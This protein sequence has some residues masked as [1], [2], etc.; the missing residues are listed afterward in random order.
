MNKKELNHEEICATLMLVVKIIRYLI[1]Q[2][3]ITDTD[4]LLLY[5]AF[6]DVQKIIDV[7]YKEIDND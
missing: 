3:K 1:D 7:H 6:C 5:N 4:T 2:D